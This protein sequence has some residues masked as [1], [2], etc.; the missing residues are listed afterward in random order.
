MTRILVTDRENNQQEVDACDGGILMETLRDEGLGVEAICGGQC[1]CATCHCLL[2]DAWFSKLDP[3]GEDESE[4]L[5]SLEHF[6]P[7]RSRL[8]CQIEITPDMA[9]LSLQIAPEE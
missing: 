7:E 1:A 8:T 4:L 2:D 3:P 6:D 9:G 5:E